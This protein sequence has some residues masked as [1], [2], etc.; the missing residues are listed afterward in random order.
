[1]NQLKTASIVKLLYVAAWILAI[2]AILDTAAALV[3]TIGLAHD[4]ESVTTALTL[5]LKNFLTAA[6]KVLVLL[7]VARGLELLLFSS[8]RYEVSA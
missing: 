7:A 8:A 3:V 2:V 4:L 5:T 1:M 6:L